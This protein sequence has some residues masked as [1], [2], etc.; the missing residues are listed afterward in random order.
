MVMMMVVPDGDGNSD[1]DCVSDSD[2]DC[3]SDGD[4]VIDYRRTHFVRGNCS[5][6]F[7]ILFETVGLC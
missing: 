5:H 2:G 1:D 4:G 6:L 3:D 7:E